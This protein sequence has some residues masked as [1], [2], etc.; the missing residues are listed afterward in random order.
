ME[1]TSEGQ[2]DK[3]PLHG[4]GEQNAHIAPAQGH[5]EQKVHA[6]PVHEH[7]EEKK[8]SGFMRWLKGGSK[9]DFYENLGYVL[10]IGGAVMVA[11]GVGL[12]SF[13][14]YTVYIGVAGALLSM[15]GIV[16]YIVSQLMAPAKEGTGAGASSSG[17]VK[18][19]NYRTNVC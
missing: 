3:A 8:K 9:A 4:H 13:I 19:V 17:S 14:K 16:L 18:V 6:V 12:G 10:M 2:H 1:D 15:L 11:M 5:G 7:H